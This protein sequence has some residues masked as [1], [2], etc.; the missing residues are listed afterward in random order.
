[1]ARRA[2]EITSAL[3][4]DVPSAPLGES[5]TQLFSI[6]QEA[7]TNAR[8]HSGAERALVS[9]NMDGDTLV[10]EVNGDGRGFG[11]DTAAG[12]GQTSM[13]EPRRSVGN[14]RSTASRNAGAGCR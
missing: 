9:V 3:P 13:R 7:L 6:L 12:V 4:D 14:R 11:A 10:T 5:G 8:R 1:V 2:R